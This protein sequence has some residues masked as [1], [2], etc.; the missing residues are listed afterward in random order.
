MSSG[1]GVRGAE[2]GGWPVPCPSV[3]A[4]WVEQLAAENVTGGCVG[5]N[6]CPM[7][8]NTREQMAVFITKSFHLQ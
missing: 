4:D 3:F 2:R 6:D 1:L 8:P 5:G 7:N